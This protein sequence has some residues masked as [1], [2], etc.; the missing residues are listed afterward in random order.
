MEFIVVNL[1]SY[2]KLEV[3]VALKIKIIKVLMNFFGL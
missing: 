2:K 1:G 3:D